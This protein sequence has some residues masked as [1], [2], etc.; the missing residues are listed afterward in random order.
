M[1]GQERSGIILPRI[2]RVLWSKENLGSSQKEANVIAR[3]NM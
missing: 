3:E 1:R 2:V